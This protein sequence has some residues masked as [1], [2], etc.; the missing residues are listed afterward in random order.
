MSLKRLTNES[1]QTVLVII[2]CGE[3][4]VECKGVHF[5]ECSNLLV[6]CSIKKQIVTAALINNYILKFILY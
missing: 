6:H 2:F 1:I 4:V 3:F 5:S